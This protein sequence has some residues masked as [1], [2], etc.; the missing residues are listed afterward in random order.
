M[1]KP[2]LVFVY[3]TLKTGNT[4]RGMQYFEG[5]EFVGEGITSDN[6]HDIFDLG[7]FPAVTEGKYKIKGEVYAVDDETFEYLD[8]IEGYPDFYNRK[9]ISVNISSA[10]VTAYMYFIDRVTL[11]N[12]YKTSPVEANGDTKEWN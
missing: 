10:K 7:S 8:A 4:T 2:R 12:S 9:K 1:K 3:G 6:I 5:A 11:L